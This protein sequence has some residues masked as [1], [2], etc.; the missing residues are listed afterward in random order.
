MPSTDD[1]PRSPDSGASLRREQIIERFEDA[2]AG[3]G[4]PDLDQF[5][6]PG[7]TR[8]L[9]ELVHADLEFRLKAGEPARV[10]G[11]LA[12]YPDLA[13]DSAAVADL[14]AAEYSLRR[15]QQPELTPDEYRQRFPHLGDDLTT[16][17]R[18]LSEQR[19]AP[20][21][22]AGD[23]PAGADTPP[24][25]S[26]EGDGDAAALRIPNYEILSEVGRGGMGVVLQARHLGLNRAVALKM[27]R[28]G[29]HA[30][31]EELARFK[32]EAE[33]VAR[34]QHPHIVQI[35]E[36]GQ[37]DGRPYFALEFVDGPSLDKKL[38]GTPLPA[39]QAAQLALTLARTIHHAHQKGIVHRDLKPA[40]ILLTADGTPKVG[41]FGLAKRLDAG[42][43]HTET[44]E[45]I[46]T[47]SYMAPEQATGKTRQVG[48][49]A[50]IYALGAILYEM[51]TGRPPFK[52]ETGVDTVLQVIHDDP[53]PPSRLQPKLPRDLETVCL[54]CLEKDPRKRYATAAELADDLQ[55]FLDG[56]PV[57]ARPTPAW[58][59]LAK[60]ARRRPAV[61]ALSGLVAGV[62]AVAFV[63]VTGLWLHA[64]QKAADERAAK[65]QEEQ[66]KKAAQEA[67]QRETDAK[68]AAVKAREDEAKERGRA[69]AK[70][71]AARAA[72]AV[73]NVLRAE[74]E[75]M[76]GHVERADHILD[77]VPWDLRQWEWDYV[78]VLC[79]GSVLTLHGHSQGVYSL[80]YSA[81]GG[82]L[83][84]G[85]SHEIIVWDPAAGK[86]VRTIKAE[87]G[88]L[89]LSPGG[90]IIAA[91]QNLGGIGKPSV[92]VKLFNA[93]SGAVEKTL[94][95]PGQ[96]VQGLA[97]SPDGKYLAA[98]TGD[99]LNQQRPGAVIVWDLTTGER[100]HLLQGH[101]ALVWAVAFSP[102][103]KRLAS[104]SFDGTV[105]VWDA[106]QGKEERVY[107]GHAG[108]GPTGGVPCVTF[109][110]DG[111]QVISGGYR[112][113]RVWNAATGEDRQVLLGHTN[114]VTRVRVSPDGARLA[115]A[116]YDRT[117]RVRDL[118]AGEEKV[119]L[120]GHSGS[121]TALDWSA[122]GTRV[123]SGG[124]FGEHVIKVWDVSGTSHGSTVGNY[125]RPVHSVAFS[126]DGTRLVTGSADWPTIP[127]PQSA[128]GEVR[129]LDAAGGTAVFTRGGSAAPVQAVAWSRDG[130][131]LVY[132]TRATTRYNPQKRANESDDPAAVRIIDPRTGQELAALSTQGAAFNAVAFTPDDKQVLAA[133]G[134]ELLLWDV[135]ADNIVRRFRGHGAE[136]RCVAVDPNGRRIASGA[137]QQFGRGPG[138]LKLWDVEKGEPLFALKGH[139]GSVQFVAFSPD[140][141]RLAS[142]AAGGGEGQ[143]GEIKVWDAEK[144]E[145][146]WSLRCFTSGHGGVAF[147]PDGK[148]LAVCG[149]FYDRTVKP[150]GKSWSEIKVFDLADRKEVL[151]IRSDRGLG[152]VAYSSDG[153]WLA[154]TSEGFNGKEVKLYRAADGKEHRTLRASAEG[155]SVPTGLAFSPDGKR[156]A[157]CGTD[158]VVRVWDVADGRPLLCAPGHPGCVRSVAY[159]PDGKHV[160]SAGDDQLVI[161]WEVPSGKQVR[162][163]AGRHVAFSAD[164]HFLAAGSG[165]GSYDATTGQRTVWGE[166]RVWDVSSGEEVFANRDHAKAVNG[167]AFSPDGKRLASG[168]WDR[169]VK[170]WDIATK[171][172]LR[173]IR[174]HGGGVSAVAFS[175]D[176]KWLATASD[177]HTARLWD[178]DTGEELFALKGHTAPVTSLA[179]HR[180]GK[181]LATGARDRTVRLWDLTTGK[182]A[183]LLRGDEAGDERRL[184]FNGVAFSPDGRQV[185]AAFEGSRGNSYQATNGV[186]LWKADPQPRPPLLVGHTGFV[187]SVAFN[188]QGDRLATNSAD[189]TVKLW[190]L[191]TGEEAFSFAGSTE[192]TGVPVDHGDNGLPLIT[193]NAVAFSK[194]GKRLAYAGPERT[195]RLIDV[196]TGRELRV[197]RGH[198]GEVTSVALSPDGTRLLSS[199]GRHEDTSLDASQRFTIKGGEVILWDAE[200]GEQLLTFREPYP[201]AL[202]AGLT[203]L[204][205]SPEPAGLAPAVLLTRLGRLRTPSPNFCGVAFSPDGKRFA[206]ATGD[207][208]TARGAGVVRVCDTATGAERWT[209]AGHTG[210][211]RAFAFSPDGERLVSAGPGTS[212]WDGKQFVTTPATIR[213]W[214]LKTGKPLR[215]MERAAECLAFSPDGRFLAAGSEESSM[216]RVTIWDAVSWREAHSFK[217]GEYLHTVSALAFSPD[218]KRLAVASNDHMTVQRAGVSRLWDVSALT[219]AKP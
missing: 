11:Y 114:W 171:K 77:T 32:A 3:G 26:R 81:D 79:Q 5:L 202:P 50:D 27:L 107:K 62:T 59:R 172:E 101:T 52:A 46:G 82:R 129:V 97:F 35:F 103:G 165:G 146:V 112:E 123:A 57:L 130:K 28:T 40:N 12:R 163:F 185:A 45:I 206:Y 115:T 13:R 88:K 124:D 186:R 100:V 44:G 179:F 219:A 197:F 199:S 217:D 149:S 173:T 181:R 68:N 108:R 6:L 198:R 211:V 106:A 126:P 4:R 208:D 147:S 94:Q 60:W 183:F 188:P 70:A 159:S 31:P 200:T 102:D 65:G 48:P 56:A 138:E 152:H 117:V 210:G 99:I 25:R 41:D 167:V 43:G 29:K 89:A 153:E 19:K 67:A 178:A 182:E 2:W 154:A 8:L 84:S 119:T 134:N 136:V 7:D 30:G 169:S 155:Y 75:V 55:R 174:G 139:T 73:G 96:G 78:R 125:R 132:G 218:G 58:E 95:A 193:S 194:D 23:T 49:A 14:A 64:D 18:A 71:R 22:L 39:L 189:R 164:G 158:A 9:I 17:L 195:V 215:T 42:P 148:K 175:P 38:R 203:A 122:D 83:V 196:Q 190:D 10:E 204:A 87:G 66:A 76:G 54:K 184:S 160:A 36:V 90:T 24:E 51:L 177:D 53:V 209:F 92:D 21:R 109:S 205:A 212:E 110:K 61:A 105:R 16:R 170:V 133:E 93:A 111:R 120:K 34:L 141:A 118:A 47:P 85:S 150:Y 142:S 192:V 137:G 143:P 69:E 131:R 216:G 74:G 161:L 135:D 72:V 33:A 121:V 191:G 127:G 116:G 180:G 20:A 37:Q 128:P 156:L 98:G 176:G 201:A 151:T 1:T 145:E 144:G 91:P 166:V 15:R 63:L 207:Y 140:G 187:Y 214:D 168:S 213:E 86:E 113:V 162:L 80:A 157:R 104:A